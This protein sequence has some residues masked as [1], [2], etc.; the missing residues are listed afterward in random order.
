M[1]KNQ[2]VMKGVRIGI[3]IFIAGEIITNG[4]GF[5]CMKLFQGNEG[6]LLMGMMGVILKITQW[7]FHFVS[8][9]FLIC[10]GKDIIYSSQVVS[11]Y[12]ILIL[13]GFDLIFWVCIATLFLYIINKKSSP[14]PK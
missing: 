8:K 7:L 10:G 12:R 14:R 4:F 3:S 11:Q 5:L 2:I 9:I 1:E 13:R 6:S